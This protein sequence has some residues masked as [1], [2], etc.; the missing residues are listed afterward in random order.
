VRADRFLW[1]KCIWLY[2]QATGME[3]GKDFQMQGTSLD[4]LG[5]VMVSLLCSGQM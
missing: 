1:T 2:S 5:L 3:V 4:S